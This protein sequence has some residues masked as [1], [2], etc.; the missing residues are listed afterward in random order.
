[1]TT[2]IQSVVIERIRP[3]ED[4]IRLK[5]DSNNVLATYKV[6]KEPRSLMED[7]YVTYAAGAVDEIY[8]LFRFVGRIRG[9]GLKV[10]M[11]YQDNV[12][13]EFNALITDDARQT[14][15]TYLTP[16][17]TVHL[18]KIAIPKG[19]ADFLTYVPIPE[20]TPMADFHDERDRYHHYFTRSTYYRMIKPRRKSPFTGRPLEDGE[21]TFYKATLDPFLEPYPVQG[22][23]DGG[24]KRKTLRKQRKQRN[25][26]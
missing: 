25:H 4:V 19:Q 1:M 15:E 10:R 7:E 18:A 3:T 20:G 12:I 13:H 21:V 17:N 8:T 26:T 11:A 6:A 16:T 22:G 14:L 2:T 9:M 23:F 5:G 24:S